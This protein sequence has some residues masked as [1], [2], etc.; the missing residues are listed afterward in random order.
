MSSKRHSS[1]YLSEYIYFYNIIHEFSKAN[2]PDAGVN[3]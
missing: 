2:T 3:K 1:I